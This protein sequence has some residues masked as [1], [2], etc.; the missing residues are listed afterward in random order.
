VRG[1]SPAQSFGLAATQR[2]VLPNGLTLLLLENHRLPIVVAEALVK[3]VRLREPAAKAG[4]AALV[5]RLLDE[6]TEGMSGEEIAQTIEAV[7]GNL[8]LSSAGGSVKVLS[9]DRSLGLR[10]F[11]DCLSRSAFPAEAFARQR[12]LQ[13]SQI[14]DAHK[15][16]NDRA[17]QAFE[18]IVYGPHP[19]GRPALGERPV[20]EK[21]TA[22]D[23]KAFHRGLFVPNNVVLAVVGDFDRQAVVEEVTRLTAGW[24]P[25]PL[26]KLELPA[27]A[28]PKEAVERIITMPAAA[29]LNVY[30][31]HVGVRRND[32]DYYQLLVMD[33]VLGSG[34][35]FTD[36]LSANLRDRQGLAYTVTGA[37]ASSA[38]E[39][40]GTFVCYIGTEAGKY[41][42][43][44]EGLLKEL[45]RIRDEPPT[46]EEVADVRKYLLGTLPFRLTTCGGVAGQ[47]LGIERHGLG[48][49]YLDDYR[50]AVT[51][52]TPAEVQAVAR[53]HL[54]LDL[55]AIVA[56]GAVD[57]QGKPVAAA[58][59]K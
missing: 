21:L 23:C 33:N 29:Q 36:R 14:D 43:V 1:D 40:P 13:L 41:A 39:E 20:V 38:G 45:R 2:V 17:L 15:K 34:A 52:V 47:L 49:H 6:G 37:I 22:D 4:I 48:F 27:P 53:K 11:L 18:G 19:L 35:G 10:L 51:A 44:K 59:E 42:V 54:H 30:L 26:A 57:A 25:V 8:E 32:P 56:A 28:G 12:E 58:P 24:K 9:P 16:P 3:D 55:L 31:G 7:G 50:K 5:G 46:A